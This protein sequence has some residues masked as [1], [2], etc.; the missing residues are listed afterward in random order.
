APSPRPGRPA[1]R[2]GAQPAGRR[3]AP[4]RSGTSTS[5]PA[6]HSSGPSPTSSTSSAAMSARPT[7]PAPLPSRSGKSS[8]ADRSGAGPLAQL[9]PPDLARE[10]LGQLGDELDLA[11]IGVRRQAF[12]HEVLD[13][14]GQLVRRRIALGE[15]DERLDDGS[16]ALVRGRHR[17]RLGDRPV[18]QAYGLDLEG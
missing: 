4:I 7:L 3:S 13:V 5:T 1:T 14:L 2:R 11:G 16:P 6:R 17:G 10:R 15:H 9:Y 12:A 18:L 8:P